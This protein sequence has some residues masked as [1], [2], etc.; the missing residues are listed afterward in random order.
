MTFLH[1]YVGLGYKGAGGYEL[2]KPHI[3]LQYSSFDVP[4]KTA[5]REELLDV[6]KRTSSLEFDTI[7]LI[8][9]RQK[10][11]SL[12]DP[13]TWEDVASFKFGSGF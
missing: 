12:M 8:Q 4:K 3:S 2:K 13:T 11:D 6:F 7:K 9:G 5:I 1:G 10:N